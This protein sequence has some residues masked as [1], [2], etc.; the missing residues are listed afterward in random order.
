MELVSRL[1]SYYQEG[2][3][4]FSELT[5]ASDGVMLNAPRRAIEMIRMFERHEDESF[6]SIAVSLRSS[7][8]R[9]LRVTKKGKT[10]RTTKWERRAQR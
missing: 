2:R 4:T 8:K 7:R 3:I 9:H 6:Q 10:R 1:L 5:G